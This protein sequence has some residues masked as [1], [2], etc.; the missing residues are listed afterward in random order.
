MS[1]LSSDCYKNMI[2]A[3]HAPPASEEAGIRYPC[4]PTSLE[5]HYPAMAGGIST[6]YIYRSITGGEEK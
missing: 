1:K 2:I 5:K 3:G 6:R 4:T